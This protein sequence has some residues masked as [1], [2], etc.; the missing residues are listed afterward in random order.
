MEK[1][2]PI[3]W[4]EGKYEVSDQWRVKSLNF[5]LTWVEWFLKQSKFTRWYVHCSK[6]SIHRLVAQAF[7]PNPE[8]KLTVNHKDWDKENNNVTNLEWATQSE[9]AK[10]SFDV[11][12]RKAPI[13]LTWKV[14][15]RKGKYWKEHGR[16]KAYIKV[17]NVG[18]RLWQGTVL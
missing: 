1:R 12:W 14:W 6:W 3:P 17:N 5:N 16:S 11:L 9:N 18:Y 2:K 15:P 4:Y 13:W 10:H 8:N 7:I